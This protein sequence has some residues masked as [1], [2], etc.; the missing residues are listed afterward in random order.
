MPERL[1]DPCRSTSTMVAPSAVRDWLDR[2]PDDDRP[3]PDWFR[4][5]EA[6]SRY[7]RIKDELADAVIGLDFDGTL[8]PIVDDPNEAR[9]HPRAGQALVAVAKR[10]RAIA[11]VTGRPARQAVAL[12]DLDELGRELAGTGHE[13]LVFGQYG[14]ERWSSSEDR[15]VSPRPPQGLASFRKELPA[16]LREYGA[17]DAYLEDKGL[18]VAVHTRRMP[19]PDWM[20][21]A[22][23]RPITDLADKHDLIVEPGRQVLEVR[24]GGANKGLVVRDLASRMD[25][26]GFIFAGDDLGDLEAFAALAEL[27]EQGLDTLRVC[28]ASDEQEVLVEQADVVVPGPDGVLALLEDLAADA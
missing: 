2:V 13:L 12:G 24:S 1:P 18:A 20:I 8:A 10:V 19:E 23:T 26:R 7:D 17:E 6:R 21:G 11:V 25:A 14:N 3:Q 5:D 9:I 15:V 28:S 4:T 27:S 16:L 22:L